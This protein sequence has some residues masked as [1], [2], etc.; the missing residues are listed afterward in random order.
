MYSLLAGI[1]LASGTGRYGIWLNLLYAKEIDIFFPAAQ[2][3][4]LGCAQFLEGVASVGPACVR[5]GEILG[6]GQLSG[7]SAVD[8]GFAP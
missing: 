3:A 5:V 4:C 6:V 1:A 7:D 2:V 8:I